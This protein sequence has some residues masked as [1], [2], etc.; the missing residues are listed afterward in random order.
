MSAGMGSPGLK[1]K[2]KAFKEMRCPNS[3]EECLCVLGKLRYY[4]C[5]CEHFSSLAEPIQRLLRKGAV[6]HFGNEQR[7][8]MDSIREE[9]C[10]LGKALQRFDLE[11][12]V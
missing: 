2:P 5:F 7:A 8:A 4:D 3:V 11:R 6:F 10:Q 1:Q 12:L 9:I